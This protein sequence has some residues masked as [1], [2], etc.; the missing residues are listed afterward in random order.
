MA[1]KFKF[2]KIKKIHCNE[3]AKIHYKELSDGIL[4]LF[5]QSYLNHFYEQMTNE[6]GWGYVVLKDKKVAGFIFSENKDINKLG[7]IRPSDMGMIII[8]LLLKPKFII[9]IL[10]SAFISRFYDS[11]DS[12][13]NVSIISQFAVSKCYQSKGIGKLLLKLFENES[14]KRS[15]KTILTSTHN[16]NL[17]NFYISEKRIKKEIVIPNIGFKNFII[18]WEL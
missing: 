7:L 11:A 18:S 3:V 8:N 15:F 9:N 14:R 5:G 10:F 1:E 2:Q 16:M 17:R 6:R 4:S 12:G 13:K